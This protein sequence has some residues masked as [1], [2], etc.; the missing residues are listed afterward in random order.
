MGVDADEDAA[1]SLRPVNGVGVHRLD[2]GV[3]AEIVGPGSAFGGSN[4]YE[5]AGG[6]LR[7]GEALC[8]GMGQV[9]G[10]GKDGEGSSHELAA[11]DARPPATTPGEVTGLRGA[12]WDQDEK[13]AR[14]QDRGVEGLMLRE[15][16]YRVFLRAAL[17]EGGI[18]QNRVASSSIAMQA[19]SASSAG[20][21]RCARSPL[22]AEYAAVSASPSTECGLEIS[23]GTRRRSTAKLHL[24]AK[25]SPAG[26]YKDDLQCPCVHLVFPLFLSQNVAFFRS[27]GTHWLTAACIDQFALLLSPSQ[28]NN[29]DL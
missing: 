13:A 25:K 10:P 9:D 5:A 28:K 12:A 7:L 22:L 21:T 2:W 23:W 4:V 29:G 15:A 14:Q 6:P 11:D 27:E 17:T 3:G 8:D 16:M 19:S 1:G 20:Y 24:R 26:F 18:L